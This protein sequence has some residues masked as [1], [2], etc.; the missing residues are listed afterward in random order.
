MC[1]D[2][3]E[4]LARA[5]EEALVPSTHIYHSEAPLEILR[6]RGVV[7]ALCQT[8]VRRGWASRMHPAYSVTCAACWEIHNRRSPYERPA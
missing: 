4:K 3:Q 5:V 1:S 6:R 7:I 2:R 8:M